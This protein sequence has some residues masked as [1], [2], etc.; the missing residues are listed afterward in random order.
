M[1]YKVSDRTTNEYK[2][3]YR[4]IDEVFDIFGISV[5]EKIR[6][7]FIEKI[8]SYLADTMQT[9]NFIAEEITKKLETLE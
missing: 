4:N 9:S 3:T 7:E 5:S 2:T 6:D 1:E 8:N